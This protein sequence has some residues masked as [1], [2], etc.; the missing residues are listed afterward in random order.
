MSPT[1]ASAIR[2]RPR[3]RRLRSSTDR[4]MRWPMLIGSPVSG[5]AVRHSSGKACWRSN[6]AAMVEAPPASA[7]CEVTSSTRA[8]SSQSSR[9]VLR[10]CSR[11]CLPVRAATVPLPAP[12][13]PTGC[14]GPLP[15]G[16]APIESGI[17]HTDRLRDEGGLVLALDLHRHL[18]GDAHAAA[19]YGL[20]VGDALAQP[21]AGAGL[22]RS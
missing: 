22:H 12:S 5:S 2:A 13:Y 16:G 20:D 19:R 21:H 8:P 7:G 17:L 10:S 6:T 15:G 3:L 11:N 4:G 18:R 1:V 9:G 14:V